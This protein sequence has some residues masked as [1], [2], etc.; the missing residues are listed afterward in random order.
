MTHQRLA[1]LLTAE[2]PGGSAAG[3]PARPESVGACLWHNLSGPV[4]GTKPK[5]VCRTRICQGLS[6]A[7]SVRACL[8]HRETNWKLLIVTGARPGPLLWVRICALVSKTFPTHTSASALA[9]ASLAAISLS[10][11]SWRALLS[12][13]TARP[14]AAARAAML[15]WKAFRAASRASS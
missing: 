12:A 15:S 2:P 9:F 11:R 4:C 3:T 13:T 7:Q 8:W 1:P 14:A 6:V 5:S 10:S